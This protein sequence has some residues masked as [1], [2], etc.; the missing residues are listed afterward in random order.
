MAKWSTKNNW[1]LILCWLFCCL[2][3]NMLSVSL[4]LQSHWH[5]PPPNPNPPLLLPP[6][7]SLSRKMCSLFEGKYCYTH[8]TGWHSI[9][10]G[11]KSNSFVGSI[12][13]L[14][15]MIIFFDLWFLFS[16]MIQRR[17]PLPKL[18]YNVMSDKELLKRLKEWNLSTKGNRTVS[19]RVLHVGNTI[20]RISALTSWSQREFTNRSRWKKLFNPFTF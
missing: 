3:A 1:R 11:T 20:I 5:Y 9:F 6:L 10:F 12:L 16:R 15:F 13:F 14:I 2:F 17:K 8:I 18:V 19:N 4:G 7:H